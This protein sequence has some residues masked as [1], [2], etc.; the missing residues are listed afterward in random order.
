[1]T[2]VAGL[3][4]VLQ[5][6]SFEDNLVAPSLDDLLGDFLGVRK[7]IVRGASQFRKQPPASV[8]SQT[9][10]DLLQ[11][12]ILSAARHEVSREQKCSF[13]QRCTAY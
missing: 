8:G 9:F 3:S 5:C 11:G 10:G 12:A 1:M 13:Y 2:M 6:A 4:D 7:S